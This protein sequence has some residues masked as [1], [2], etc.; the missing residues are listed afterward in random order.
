MVVIQFCIARRF[1][2][3]AGAPDAVVDV[4][5]SHHLNIGQ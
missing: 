3:R 2:L 1:E 4:P 5:K